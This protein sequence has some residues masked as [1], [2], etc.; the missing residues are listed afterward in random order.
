MKTNAERYSRQTALEEI[1]KEGQ[2]KLWK[3][4][5]AVIGVGGSGSAAVLYLA[6]AGI[7]TLALVDEDA[8]DLTNIHR[9]IVHHT[10]DVDKA[11]VISA[12]E[13]VNDINPDIEVVTYNERADADNIGKIIKGYDFVLDCTDDFASKFLI[14]DACVAEGKA[15]SHGGVTRFSGQTLTYVPGEACY[16]C[17]FG[18]MPC[19]GAVRPS[20]ETGILG[21]VPGVMGTV[22]ATEAIK[23]L[24][25]AGKLLT[26]RLLIF[27]M[28][29]MNFRTV[30]IAKNRN[31]SACGQDS[32]LLMDSR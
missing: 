11:K 23:Y 25:G 31:C 12:K 22:Q 30:R 6:G 7:G 10:S 20:S 16:R 5:V 3:A 1:G 4:K 21:T 26:D 13:K 29:E 15:Y 14:N 19:E 18:D 32:S 8:V 17:V 28:L 2:E 9:Q 24:T 27:D